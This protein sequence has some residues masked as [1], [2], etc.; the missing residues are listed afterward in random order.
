[1]NIK[2]YLISI[3]EKIY[4]SEL[5]INQIYRWKNRNHRL[6][7][8][9]PEKSILYML[10]TNCSIARFGDGEFE[11]ILQPNQ[12]LGFQNSNIALSQKLE[13][14]L[15]N[16]NKNLLICIPYTLNS[17]RGRT[18]HSRMFWY[19]WGIRNNHHHRIVDL[20]HR[21]QPEYVFGDAQITRP[22]I[23]YRN[24]KHG[25]RIFRLLRRIWDGQDL[26]LVEGEKT[27]LGVGNDLFDNAHSIK[28]VLCPATNAF[29][30]Y[31]EI[32]NTVVDI[33]R[34]ELILIALGPTATVLAADFADRGMR[35]MDLGHFDIEYDWFLRGAKGHE[36]VEGKFTNEATLGYHVA[37]CADPKY[38]KSIVRHIL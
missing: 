10:R 4:A 2:Q 11:M 18:K 6:N 33:W 14:V 26:L 24:S 13:N 17:L 36:K 16:Q 31:D 34:G 22:Y 5:A 19:T 35:A 37:E 1:M 12:N 32:F 25:A 23:A 15:Q 21:Y 9:T 20:I 3:Y 29:D 27:R 30:R 28:R 7:I 38:N 8:M